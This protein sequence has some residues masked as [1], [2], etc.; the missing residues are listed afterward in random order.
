EAAY[1]TGLVVSGDGKILT[2]LGVYL[3]GERIRVVLPDGALHFAQ[4]ERRSDAWQLA[5][6]KID[7]KTPNFFELPAKSTVERRD[8][9]VAASNAFRVADG[10]EPLSATLG[11]VSLR[12]PLELKRGVQNVTYSGDVL[13]IDCITSNAGAPG[14]AVVTADGELAGMVGRLVEDKS[15]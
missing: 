9:L 13:V 6:L 1:A 3:G 4:V 12:T 8:W 11:V 2:S 10:S 14:G 15:T 7:A 5:L